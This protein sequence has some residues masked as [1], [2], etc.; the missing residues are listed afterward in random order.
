MLFAV[1]LIQL[2]TALRAKVHPIEPSVVEERRP[3]GVAESRPADVQEANQCHC[4]SDKSQYGEVAHCNHDKRGEQDTDEDHEPWEN[5]SL[6]ARVAT[7]QEKAGTPDTE[8]NPHCHEHGDH[9]GWVGTIH[10]TSHA[11]R[12]G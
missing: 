7:P 9:H 4:R 10:G 1:N 8:G 12:S 5:R 3:A 11:Q 6:E 2:S